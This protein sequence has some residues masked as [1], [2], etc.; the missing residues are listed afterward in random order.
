[1][2]TGQELCE[3]VNRTLE[4]SYT[5]NGINFSSHIM[6]VNYATIIVDTRSPIEYYLLNNCYDRV[7]GL[8]TS[9]YRNVWNSSKSGL[10]IRNLHKM[11]KAVS[12][13]ALR[14]ICGSQVDDIEDFVTRELPILLEL[15]L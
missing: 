1:M 3:K 13:R 6:S 12:N 11:L 4:L 15:E 8:A 10:S 5:S 14:I 9:I 2:I 7:G